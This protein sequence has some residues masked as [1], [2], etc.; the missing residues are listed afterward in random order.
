MNTAIIG[1]GYVGLTLSSLLARTGHRTYCIDV[2]PEKID[3]IKTG[4]SYFYELGLDN[5]V[6]Y[7]IDSGNLIPTLDYEEGLKDADV[8]FLCVGTPSGPD[9]GLDLTY[10]FDAVKKAAKYVKDGVIFVQ[11]STVPV[12]TGREAIRLM[13]EVNPDLKFTYLSC[14][15]YLREGAA[16][17]DSIIQDRVVIGGDDKKAAGKIFDLFEKIEKEA[18]EICS[19]TPEIS[20][21]ANAYMKNNNHKDT[22]FS[23]KCMVMCLESAELVKVCSNTFLAMK[24]SFAN[25]IARICDSVDANVNEVMDG[26]GMDRRIN[27]SFLYAGL[28]F[29]GG[30]FPKDVKGLK[31]SLE[32]HN[33]DSEFVK[34]VWKV[35]EEQV[36]YVVEQMK[37]MDIKNGAKVGMLGL[38]FKPGTSDVRVSPACRLG[39]ALAQAGF[40]ITATD[41]QAIEDARKEFPEEDNLKYVDT[42][43]EVFDG[44]QIVVLATDWPEFKELDFENL[45]RLMSSKNFYDARNC[46][47]KEKMSKIFN[48]DNLGA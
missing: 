18:E 48:F 24:I 7:G 39:K 37:K 5:L 15:E 45:S 25:N 21:Y 13:K 17:L 3:I 2:I 38:A 20:Q 41:P 32:E 31:K 36:E 28:G 23:D 22:N 34:M 10:I 46:L 4:K 1:T 30:C 8:V 26:V 11:R 44:A 6:K 33:I 43:E 12:G 47:D 9:G 35:N 27:R 16:V 14:P 40:N 19:E 42:V 29:G